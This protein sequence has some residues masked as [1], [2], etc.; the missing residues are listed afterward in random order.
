VCGRGWPD[1]LL[2]LL[3]YYD[4][5]VLIRRGLKFGV[6]IFIQIIIT[7][8]TGNVITINRALEHSVLFLMSQLLAYCKI[9]TNVFREAPNS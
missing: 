1:L 7:A 2:V 9:I 3:Q 8:V 6:S 5:F 4:E